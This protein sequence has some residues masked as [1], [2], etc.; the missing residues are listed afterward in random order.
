MEKL[1]V[2]LGPYRSG[3]SLVSQILSDLGVWFGPETKFQLP[4]DRYNPGG[5]FQRRDVVEVNRRLIESASGSIESPGKPDTILAEG[6]MGVLDFVDLAWTKGVDLAGLK[7]PR[8]SITLL[9][10]IR[11]GKFAQKELRIVRVERRL[12]DVVASATKH[13][14]VGSFGDYDA[15]RLLRMTE[16]Y[17]RY[18]AWHTQNLD[19]PSITVSFD[20]LKREP[21]A[22][23]GELGV[24]LDMPDSDRVSHACKRVGKQRVLFKHYLKKLRNPRGLL[25]GLHKTAKHWLKR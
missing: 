9:S 20:R 7:D 5:Y 24:F 10:W 6:D 13:H 19:V 14:E 23:I 15:S 12:S 1:V 8:F 4:A 2:V 21:V 18:A 22:L 25:E 3:T 17:H 11:A 16:L